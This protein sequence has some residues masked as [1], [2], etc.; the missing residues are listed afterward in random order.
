MTKHSER[1]ASFAMADARPIFLRWEKLRLLYNLIVGVVGL[2]AIAPHVIDRINPDFLPGPAMPPLLLVLGMA[3]YALAANVCY[4]V[5]PALETYL[6]WLGL[7]IRHLTAALFVAG[8]L[9][10]VA[11]TAFIALLM[12]ARMIMHGLLIGD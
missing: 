5:G 12:W 4:F 6:A 7:K 10:S 3:S 1:G 8:A 2:L 9:F 11:L